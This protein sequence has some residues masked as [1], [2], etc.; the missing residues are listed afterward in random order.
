MAKRKPKSG[1]PRS[2][3]E[4][5]GA[6]VALGCAVGVDVVALLED[7]EYVATGSALEGVG[8]RCRKCGCGD[9]NPC[10]GGCVWVQ[11]DLCSRCV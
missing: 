8:P 2:Q 4:A 6:L 1:K 10:P 3:P 9:F 7:P 5:L 11:P